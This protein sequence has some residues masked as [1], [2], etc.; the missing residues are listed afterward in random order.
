[1][2]LGVFLHR[3]AEAP[4]NTDADNEPEYRVAY[5]VELL[6]TAHGSMSPAMASSML[7]CI[8]HALSNSF[9]AIL[10]P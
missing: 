1:M 8:Y 7:S 6:M 9:C 5:V 3:K 4:K 2:V 10:M